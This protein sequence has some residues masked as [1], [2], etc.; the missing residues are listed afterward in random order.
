MIQHII[1]IFNNITRDCGYFLL[2]T[3]LG[4][5]LQPVDNWK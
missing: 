2:E 3:M 5:H 1:L 4:L